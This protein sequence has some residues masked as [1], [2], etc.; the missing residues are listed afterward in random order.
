[1]VVDMV[2]NKLINGFRWLSMVL[3]SKNGFIMISKS[4]KI[5]RWLLEKSHH[6]TWGSYSECLQIMGKKIWDSYW[7][8]SKLG[9][10]ILG[11]SPIRVAVG[12]EPGDIYIYIIIIIIMCVSV[13]CY[14]YNII[15]IILFLSL[16]YISIHM[17]VYI[18][19]Y[20]CIIYIIVN[21]YICILLYICMYSLVPASGT[22]DHLN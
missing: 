20:I 17:C 9:Q 7:I 10:F 6:Q 2:Y 12:T 18:V 14:I 4:G 16:L 15:I 1:M 22:A 5:W 8:Q 3:D 19:I 13:Y 11:W 21:I